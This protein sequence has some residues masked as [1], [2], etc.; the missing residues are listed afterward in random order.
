MKSA[1]KAYENAWLWLAKIASGVLV[2]VL[3]M[4]HLVANHVVAVGGLMDYNAVVNYL[5]HP[6]IT[7]MESS[8]L[9]IVVT[10]SLLGTRSIILDLNPPVKLLKFIDAFM[11]LL[12]LAATGYGIW[13]IRLIVIRGA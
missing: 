3:I 13:L 12:G 8:F 11:L 7:F 5:S 2:V 1:P 9:I 6:W 10:H 4:V